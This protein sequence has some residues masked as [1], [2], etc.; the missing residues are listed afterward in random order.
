M[1][2]RSR[3]PVRSPSR[4][5]TSAATEFPEGTAL[6]YSSFGRTTR[7]S[8]SIPVWKN[9]PRSSIREEPDEIV[10]ETPR[11]AEPAEVA[12]PGEQG[13]HRGRE[14]GVIVRVRDAAGRPVPPRTEEPPVR[15][16]QVRQDEPGG[17]HRGLQELG[18]AEGRPRLGERLDR[19][20][21][22]AREDLVVRRGT[23]ASLPRLEQDPPGSLE[24]ARVGRRTRAAAT[25]RSSARSPS[26]LPGPRR[27]PRRRPHPRARPA[28]PRTR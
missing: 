9:P 10:G 22:P 13:E 12:R 19:H 4:C 2:S 14:Q 6:S 25:G 18:V 28:P 24:V 27:T 23:H 20:R 15:R 17:R 8:P 16:A 21:V 1:P 3:S 11:L 7:G 5:S 26:S